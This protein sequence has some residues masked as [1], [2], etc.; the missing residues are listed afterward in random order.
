MSYSPS[1][2][3]GRL[4]SCLKLDA[5]PQAV[6]TE[7]RSLTSYT[8]LF[9]SRAGGTKELPRCAT[10]SWRTF[11]ARCA[12][13]GAHSSIL[14]SRDLTGSWDIT[15][16]PTAITS[17]ELTA[18]YAAAPASSGKYMLHGQAAEEM[19]GGTDSEKSTP[20]AMSALLLFSL[21]Y[22]GA[23]ENAFS[24]TPHE[25]N[26][27]FSNLGSLKLR[28]LVLATLIL[29]TIRTWY[30]LV[31]PTSVTFHKRVIVCSSTVQ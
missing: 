22:V 13:S 10:K 2:L 9:C 23:I 27:L 8:L 4:L 11:G 12:Q 7:R 29:I 31:K 1:L 30:N 20:H 14:A 24:K 21:S 6:H 28:S 18:C 25:H 5:L 16:S 17:C 3:L 15:V 26:T 19:I